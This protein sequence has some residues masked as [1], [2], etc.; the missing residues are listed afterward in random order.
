MAECAATISNGTLSRSD[1]AAVDAGQ[2][3]HLA[4]LGPA[5]VAPHFATEYERG[6]EMFIASAAGGAR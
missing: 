3:P 5:L 4:A 2:F 1:P 6:L